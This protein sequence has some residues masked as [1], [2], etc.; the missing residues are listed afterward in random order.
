MHLQGR[1]CH[2][3]QT[4]S[5][6]ATV[7]RLTLSCALP[8]WHMLLQMSSMVCSTKVLCP[9]NLFLRKSQRYKG[10]MSSYVDIRYLCFY[11]NTY[12]DYY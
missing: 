4:E 9:Q 6:V 8:G 12:C 7:A 10:C 3:P 11:T 1:E 2:E 5:D